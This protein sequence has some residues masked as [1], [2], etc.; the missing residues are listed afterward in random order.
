MS[1]HDDKRR[2]RVLRISQFNAW[3]VVAIASFF[4][5]V[6]LGSLSVVGFLVGACVTLSGLLEIWGHRLLQKREP[7]ARLWMT[8]SQVWL[9]ICVLL[10]CWW[11]LHSLDPLDPF[12]GLLG[13][14]HLL[15][16]AEDMGTPR[17]LVAAMF[18]QIYD[19]TYKLVAL[20][21]VIFQGGLGLYYWLQVGRIDR[22][23]GASK[24]PI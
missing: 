9:L 11:R 14:D 7:G 10:Y 3:C 16:F 22:S 19:L 4:A 18:V 6:S 12:A 5:V 24:K 13:V 8:V 17:E 1:D 20:L 21:T 15:E 2:Q 23:F